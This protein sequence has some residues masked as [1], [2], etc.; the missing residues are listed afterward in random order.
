[1]TE[2]N[3]IDDLADGD[4][5]DEERYVPS[6]DVSCEPMGSKA[7][8]FFAMKLVRRGDD[9]AVLRR[10]MGMTPFAKA[11][12]VLGLAIGVGFV[13]MGMWG[14]DGLIRYL[15]PLALLIPL[16]SAYRM[17]RRCRPMTFDRSEGM[18]WP[19]RNRVD[20]AG[21]DHGISINRI[22][23]IQTLSQ[24]SFSSEGNYSCYDLNL[25]L[26]DPPGERIHVMCVSGLGRFIDCCF[27]LSEFLNK[28]V[29]DA[30]DGKG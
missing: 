22:D 26:N 4:E 10:V 25:V 3:E 7:L 1:M 11:C 16:G 19:G 29:W 28:P 17:W 2:L 21:R 9:V 23:C 18:F 6:F 13:V 8:N 20:S 24:Y 12:T 27:D 5:E 15:L 14:A 30:N